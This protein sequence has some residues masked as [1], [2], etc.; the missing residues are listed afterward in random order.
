MKRCPEC[1][2]EYD[3]TMMFCLDDGAELLYGPAR[4]EP[5]AVATGFPLDE[6]QTAILNSTAAPGEASTHAR[7]NATDQAAILRAGAEAQPQNSLAD[8]TEK[9]SFSARQAQSLIA[10]AVL[11]AVLVGGFFVYRYF[12]PAGTDQINSIAVLPF[13]NRSGNADT[14]YLSDGLA[15]SLIYRLSQL[16]NLKVSPTSSVMRYKGS[17]TDVAQ[18]AKELE[19]GAVMSGR[20]VQRGDDLSISVQLIDARTKKLIWAEQYDRQMAD[21]LAT[22]REIA[23]TITQKLQLKLLGDEAKGITKKYTDN[24]DAYQL[25]LKGRYHLAKRT[26]DD[27]LKGIEYFQRAIKLDP[28]FALAY[29]RICDSYMSMPAYPYMAPK[30]AFP[31]AKAAALRAVEIDPTLAEGHTF[32][33]MTLAIADW[34][35]PEAERE[36]KR[37]IELDPNNAAAHFRY[38][39]I[40]LADMGRI[41]EAIAKVKQALE[42]EPLD[43]NMGANLAWLYLF[44]RKYDLAVEQARK[45]YEMEPTFPVGRWMLGETYA[46]SGMYDESIAINEQTLK[47]D[48]TSQFA[49]RNIGFAYARSGRRREAE[50][51]VQRFKDLRKTQYVLSYRF[52]SL[53]AALGDRDQAFIE[54]D[55]AYDERDWQL[56]RIKVDPF[57]DS[58]RDDPRFKELLKRMNLPE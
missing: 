45:V 58:L 41:D 40:Y 30:E 5:R 12:K 43:L 52:A 39:Q 35:W 26:K 48:P 55:R 18:I 23:T 8:S 6:P 4:S 28:N 54:L 20:L 19:V 50:E 53:Y 24:N 3:N 10:A 22:Q 13:E 44:A 37:G 1:G 14:D 11:V 38:G 2:R 56:Q 31:Q 25:Y 27:I 57:W 17:A 36:F 32:L 16:P 21:L 51:I 33:A 42:L 7:I 15:D 46:L 34:N 49:L 47:T 29:A 9:R